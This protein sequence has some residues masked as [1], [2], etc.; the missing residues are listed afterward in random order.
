MA[1]SISQLLNERLRV[2]ASDLQVLQ[3]LPGYLPLRVGQ[4]VLG[5]ARVRRKGSAQD[6]Y[7]IDLP[8]AAPY[9]LRAKRF[10]V[11]NSFCLLC[12][13]CKEWR[14]KLFFGDEAFGL[15]SLPFE[16]RLECKECVMAVPANATVRR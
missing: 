15:H 13:T 11:E 2:D 10:S 4:K 9:L 16:N 6:V 12:H 8:G 1:I 3:R 14:K 7:A 5:H